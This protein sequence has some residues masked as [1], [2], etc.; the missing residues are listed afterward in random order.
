MS[1]LS[2]M[3]YSATQSN[4]TLQTLKNVTAHTPKYASPS[5]LYT[6]MDFT[7]TVSTQ[8]S[9]GSSATATVTVTCDIFDELES[10]LSMG[11]QSLDNELWSVSKSGSNFV[12]EA[13]RYGHGMGMSQRGAMYMAKLGY[14]YDQILGFYY[15]GC[16][17]CS[18]A[19]PIPF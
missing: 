2:S 8:N 6:K 16:K 14:T 1:K 3:G 11:I 13:R 9:A 19:L 15:D 7:F 5:R 17:R 10:L 12:L 18:I 4:T